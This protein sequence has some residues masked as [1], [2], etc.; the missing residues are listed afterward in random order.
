M[1]GAVLGPFE[2]TVAQQEIRP[3]AE[4]PGG[5]QV[6]RRTGPVGDG[7][8]DEELAHRN[9]AWKGRGTPSVGNRLIRA[10]RKFL[11][12]QRTGFVWLFRRK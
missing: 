3:Q 10:R 12:V 8:S 7:V 4:T 5:S 2:R 6:V 11:V 1:T 9:T